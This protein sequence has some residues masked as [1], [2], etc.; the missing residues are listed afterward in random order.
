MQRFYYRSRPD[1]PTRGTAGGHNRGKEPPRSI[2]SPTRDRHLRI[3]A[4][5][6]LRL[7][8]DR[9]G[10]D[11][12]LRLPAGL[13]AGAGDWPGAALRP[14]LGDR[15]APRGR[16]RLRARRPDRRCRRSAL[17]A[18]RRARWRPRG[19]ARRRAGGDPGAARGFAAVHRGGALR[20]PRDQ[21]RPGHVP[22]PAG[23]R[24]PGLGRRLAAAHPGISAG[25]ALGRGRPSPGPR[26]RRRPGLRR[27]H[28]LD[29]GARLPDRAGRSRLLLSG[30]AAARLAAGR[31]PLHGRLLP[32][33]G[34]LQGD[35]PGAVRPRLRDRVA[36]AAR[37]RAAGRLGGLSAAGGP[38]W[39]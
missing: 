30:T 15:P 6:L 13:L 21:L 24:P 22:A 20:H 27:L 32:R 9:S 8:A 26:D 12:A 28:P 10:R 18:A 7:A 2:S 38:A 11:R 23:R 16:D 36:G 14:L 39:P 31:P 34:R 19:P 29:R 33:P 3:G 35:N 5:R 25:A 37:R 17:P 4:R 1:V